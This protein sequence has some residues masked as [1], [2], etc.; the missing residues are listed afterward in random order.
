MEINLNDKVRVK[1]NDLGREIHKKENDDHPEYQPPEEDE[2][3]WSEWQLW[4]LMRTFG[5]HMNLG[6]KVP[7]ETTIE[8]KG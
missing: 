6:V 8:L 4:T 3:G 1:L 7:F 2:N 5:P